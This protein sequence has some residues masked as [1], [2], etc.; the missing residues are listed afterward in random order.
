MKKVQNN[1]I[2]FTQDSQKYSSGLEILQTN[3]FWILK[4]EFILKKCLVANDFQ[5]LF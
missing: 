2:R 3:T 5:K 4:E 1:S